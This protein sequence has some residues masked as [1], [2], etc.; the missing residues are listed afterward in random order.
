M[1]NFQYSFYRMPSSPLARFGL[2]L[3]GLAIVTLSLFIGV[4]FLA[5]VA[6]LAI[7]GAL[8]MTVRNWLT[9]GRKR[10]RAEDDEP[11]RVEYRVIR[12]DRD[13]R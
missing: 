1:R 5:V 13:Q 8:G 2:A 7:L 11:L 4:I 9:G 10:N 6:G 12:T 3:A